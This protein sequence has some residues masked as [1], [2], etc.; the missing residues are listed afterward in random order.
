MAK[1]LKKW[2]HTA[3]PVLFFYVQIKLSFFS[4][5]FGNRMKGRY[6]KALPYI[7][8]LFLKERFFMAG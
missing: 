5:A 7:Y 3:I 4:T 6:K 1:K 8:I 2:F